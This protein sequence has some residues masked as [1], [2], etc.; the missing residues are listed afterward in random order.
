MWGKGGRVS[1]FFGGGGGGGEGDGGEKSNVNR[2]VLVNLP[3]YLWLLIGC[4]WEVIIYLCK[5]VATVTTRI[6][7]KRNTKYE[8]FPLLQP[9]YSEVFFFIIKLNS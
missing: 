7:V 6:G 1:F 8:E 4:K 9:F 3:C 5:R 2:H